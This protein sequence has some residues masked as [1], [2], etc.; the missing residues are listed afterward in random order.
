MVLGVS[1]TTSFRMFNVAFL[2]ID[3]HLHIEEIFK[4]LPLDFV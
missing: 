4:L 3:K 2:I 1:L